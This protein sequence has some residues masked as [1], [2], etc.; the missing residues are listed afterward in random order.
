V[1]ILN[2]KKCHFFSSSFFLYKIE[3]QEGEQVLPGGVGTGGREE[4]VRKW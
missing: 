2:K 4:E 3:K 1:A